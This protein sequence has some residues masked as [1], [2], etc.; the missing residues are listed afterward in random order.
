M[1]ATGALWDR[2]RKAIERRIS[3]EAMFLAEGKAT[4]FAGYREKVGFIRGLQWVI[5]QAKE[6]N[7]SGDRPP[8]QE[9]DD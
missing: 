2:L 1:I 4:D 3:D 6:I 5:G 8:Q 9:D 7:K